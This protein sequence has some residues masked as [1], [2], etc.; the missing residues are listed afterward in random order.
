MLCVCVCVAVWLCGCVAVWLCVA[1]VAAAVMR[2][3]PKPRQCETRLSC[4]P[5]VEYNHTTTSVE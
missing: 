2:K 4:M 5:G 1:V 3:D